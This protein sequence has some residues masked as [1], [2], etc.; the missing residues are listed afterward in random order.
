VRGTQRAP[1]AMADILVYGG[2]VG[3]CAAALTAARRAPKGAE[4]VLCFPEPLP[5]GMATVG[6]LSAWERRLWAHGGRRADPQGG[7]FAMWLE[8]VGPVFHPEGFAR[9]LAGAL[10]DAGVRVLAGHDVEA[11]VPEDAAGRGRGRG[12][13]ARKGPP[14]GIAAVHVRRLAPGAAAF[15]AGTGE[16]IRARVF[17]DASATGRLARLAGVPLSPGR[18]DWHPDG[19]QMAASLLFAVQGVDWDA[20]VGARDAQDKPVWGTSE[21]VGPGGAHRLFWGGR[22]VALQDPLLREFAQAHP[23]VRIGPIRAWEEAGGA[24]WV[25]TLLLYDVDARRRAYDQGTERDVE[26]VPPDALD[27]DAAWQRARALAGASDVLG[28]LRRFPGLERVRVARGAD[29]QPR[30]GGVLLVRESAH[31]IAPGPEPFALTVAD[32][33]G[34][35]AVP[36]EGVDWRHRPRRVGLGFYWLENLGYTPDELLPPTAAAAN[37][38]YLPLDVLL[39]PPVANLLVAGHAARIDSRAWWAMRTLPN[40]AVLGDAAGVAAAY[41]VREEVPVL[42]FGNPEVAA[43]QAWLAE[44]GAILE[45]W[46]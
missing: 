43:V 31:A 27:L 15:D 7:S 11:V 37:P 3:G 40:L 42:R 2:E 28:C 17:I 13:R 8:E 38:C 18:S 34:A 36:G 39:C 24:F 1:D 46:S 32:V 25:Q 16:E 30:T 21:E 23:G 20:V 26:P 5:G 9:A 10:A 22:Q 14:Q 33:T 35:G 12:R 29:G 45:K 19:R 44:E 41:S 6:G 4:I